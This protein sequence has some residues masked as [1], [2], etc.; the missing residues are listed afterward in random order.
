ME[1]EVRIET[2]EGEAK[3]VI[4]REQFPL[5]DRCWDIELVYGNRYC[6]LT[7]YWKGEVK[8]SIR[9]KQGRDSL[10]SKIE[11]FLLNAYELF[12]SAAPTLS[13]RLV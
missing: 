5:H 7:F 11:A 13:P 6:L 10:W 4:G 8:L 9:Y 3:L 1:H 12:R 2:S